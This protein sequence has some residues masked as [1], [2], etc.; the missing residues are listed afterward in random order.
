MEHEK[1]INEDGL[2]NLRGHVNPSVIRN[3]SSGEYEIHWT[4]PFCKDKLYMSAVEYLVNYTI[5]D[6]RTGFAHCEGADYAIILPKLLP[7]DFFK[8]VPHHMVQ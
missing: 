7:K 2:K 8:N 6:G 5:E 1:F 3:P 4:C